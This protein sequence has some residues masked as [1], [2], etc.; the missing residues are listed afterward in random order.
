MA[1]KSE[2]E[3]STDLRQSGVRN[4]DCIGDNVTGIEK[5][6]TMIIQNSRRILRECGA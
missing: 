5:L 3:D 6:Q 2:I 4:G 1:V